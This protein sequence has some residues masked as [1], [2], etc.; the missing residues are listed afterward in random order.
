M[1]SVVKREGF[2][3]VTLA[4]I[5]VVA[6]LLR[7]I[8]QWD[9]VFV[10]GHIYYRGNDPWY[11]M[12]LIDSMMVNFPNPIT[13]D[14]F[15]GFP[16]GGIPGYY[17]FMHW[18]VYIFG[19]FWDYEYVAAFLP[20][21]LGALTLIPL[22][23]IGKLLMNTKGALIA[24]LFA[25]LLPGEFLHRTLL[26][27]ADHHA[28][29]VFLS[30]TCIM[31]LMLA[32]R[33]FKWY[34]VLGAG[35]SLGCYILNW[36]GSA[37]F[38][39]II[40]V[41]WWLEF[42]YLYKNGQDTLKICKIVVV[43]GII[44]MFMG[45]LH[46]FNG[47]SE[48]ETIG[49][50]MAIIGAPI[51]VYALSR[52]VKSK[53]NFFFVL[54]FTVPIAIILA[55]KAY[56]WED[57]LDSVFRGG[58]LIQET[59]W[60]DPADLFR[61]YGLVFL[62]GL[63]G[64]FFA[65]KGIP[66][67]KKPPNF[68]LLAWAGIMLVA[69]ISQLRWGYY[70]TICL[71]L[72]AA[73]F[74]VGSNFKFKKTVQTFVLALMLSFSI[75]PSINQISE[76]SALNNNITTSWY[77][78]CTWLRYNTPDPY[79]YYPSNKEPRGDERF[80]VDP[81]KYDPDAFYTKVNNREPADYGIMSWWDYGNFIMRIGHRVPVSAP[82]HDSSYPSWFFKAKSEEEADRILEGRRIEY[83]IIHKD[84]LTGLWP[85]IV[86]LGQ[87]T[88][89]EVG[90]LRGNALLFQI[91]EGKTKWIHEVYRVGNIRVYERIIPE[92]RGDING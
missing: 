86:Y 26:G 42:L 15:G 67:E 72:L 39:M 32:N 92:K 13:W 87:G 33:N 73:Y 78:A 79:G 83:V 68:L 18:V 63:G 75:I 60:A 35:V 46:I 1:I 44:G 17:P 82:S 47:I 40:G 52:I 19:Q 57:A 85:A 51:G 23:V 10:D 56:A 25:A 74:I 81:D 4:A 29:E 14:M 59:Q 62:L 61:S 31:F 2:G 76:V 8:P 5:M 20:P 84:M 69:A 30:T 36:N 11:H 41:W 66:E 64:F 50:C 53:E 6:F 7:V 70:F 28:F 49:A 43:T 54:A 27:F 3:V 77:D 12:R 16:G 34:W 58:A 88:P 90:S 65:Y 21:V 71:S 91:W 55:H 48:K 9:K 24:C 89:S 45:F 22:F 37:F 80:P 38:I